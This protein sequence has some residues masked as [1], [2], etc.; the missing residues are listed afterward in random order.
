MIEFESVTRSFGGTRAVDE[1]TLA[2]ERGTICA[3]VGTSGSGKSTLLRLVNRLLDPDG[4]RIRLDGV[5][6]AG[7]APVELRRRMGYVIQ[8][9]G[10]FPHWTVERNVATVPLLLGWPAARIAARVAEL[11]DL[12]GLAPDVHARRYP[13]ELSGGQQQRVGVARALAADPEL[14]LMDE[15]FGAVDPP[16]R[17]SLQDSLAAIQKRTGTTII[18]VT[19][20]VE[21]AIRLGGTLAVLE[22]GRLVQTGTPAAVLAHPANE[23]V[24][25]FFGGPLLGLHLLQALNVGNRANFTDPSQVGGEPIDADASLE[26]ALAR[27]I[28]EGTS[29]LPVVNPANGR[30]GVLELAELVGL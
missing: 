26:T 28:A 12:V 29:R 14:L 17:R 1:V 21:E 18:I 4:G 15:P 27:M 25:R 7:I 6:I 10:L 2:V 13:D 20:D 23:Q 3:L 22:H 30:R 16:T 9:V 8:S 11:L 19:H 5:D 24:A